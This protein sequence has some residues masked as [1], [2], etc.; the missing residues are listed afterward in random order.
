MTNFVGKIW[1]AVED[2]FGSDDD[3]ASDRGTIGVRGTPVPEEGGVTTKA[4]AKA[5]EYFESVFTFTSPSF[6][7]GGQGGIMQ[8]SSEGGDFDEDRTLPISLEKAFSQLDP[9][10]NWGD[11]HQGPG[12]FVDEIK[13]I[14]LGDPDDP[15][16]GA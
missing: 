15:T 3:T 9:W 6:D 7:Q 12:D 8:P 14:P 5:K 1:A 11:D 10:I 2:T 16:G 4:G 13:P